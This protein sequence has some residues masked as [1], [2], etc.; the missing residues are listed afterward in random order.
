MAFT[1]WM[2]PQERE[3]KPGDG[4]ITR[5]HQI[6]RGFKEGSTDPQGEESGE[7]EPSSIQEE[8]RKSFISQGLDSP[9]TGYDL[10]FKGKPKTTV[11]QTDGGIRATTGRSEGTIHMTGMPGDDYIANLKQN[12]TPEQAKDVDN[13]IAQNWTPEEI[14]KLVEG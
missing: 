6:W 5:A 4:L 10:V 2:R 8:P 12:L 13:L 14:K 3:Y 11:T 7:Q 9:S 1:G